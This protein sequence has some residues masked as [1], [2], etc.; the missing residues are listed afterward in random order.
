[1]PAPGAADRPRSRN[2]CVQRDRSCVPGASP[3]RASVRAREPPAPRRSGLTPF[4]TV[5]ERV[6]HCTDRRGPLR[7]P[8][9]RSAAVGR[10]PR[11]APARFRDVGGLTSTLTPNVEMNG[12]VRRRHHRRPR[13]RPP[14]IFVHMAMMRSPDR[15]RTRSGLDRARR[16]SSGVNVQGLRWGQTTTSPSTSRVESKSR[17]RSRSR[18]VE[19]AGGKPRGRSPPETGGTG[20]L[21]RRDAAIAPAGARRARALGGATSTGGHAPPRQLQ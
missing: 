6:R 8:P 18:G 17:A 5:R 10:Q 20:A 13:P 14:L 19:S 1:M 3:T 12:D 21:G 7:H 4:H 15:R 9:D 16:R 2:P 11:T